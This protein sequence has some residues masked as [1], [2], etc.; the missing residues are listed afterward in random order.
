MLLDAE[1]VYLER[2]CVEPVPRVEHYL[3][4]WYYVYEIGHIITSRELNEKTQIEP[5]SQ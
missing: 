1:P 5:F 3:V 4:D 2:N